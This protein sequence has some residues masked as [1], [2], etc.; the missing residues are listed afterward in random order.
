MNAHKKAV[1]SCNRYEEG[2]CAE[3]EEGVS[4]VKERA[5]RGL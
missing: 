3:K 4:V 1:E 2:I 5:G